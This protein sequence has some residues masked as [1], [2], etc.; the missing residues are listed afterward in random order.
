MTVY[1]KVLKQNRLY[2][3]ENCMAIYETRKRTENCHDGNVSV[4]SVVMIRLKDYK[5]RGVGKK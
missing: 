3:C 4:F 5:R 2:R 1:N